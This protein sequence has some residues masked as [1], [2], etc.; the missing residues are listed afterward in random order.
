MTASAPA[1]EAGGE[2]GATDGHVPSQEWLR[3]SNERSR[4]EV[5]VARRSGRC[6][7]SLG[8]LGQGGR[9]REPSTVA[10][11][12]Q[13]PAFCRA[14][15][16]IESTSI[17]SSAPAAKPSTAERTDGP[18]TSATAYPTTVARAHARP[19]ASH[20]ST[21]GRRASPAARI[22]VAEPI[23]SGRLE[24]KIATSSATPTPPP[25]ARPI[26]RT[27]CSGMPSSRAPSAIGTPAVDRELRPP[28]RATSRLAR[29]Y[30]AAPTAS[31]IATSV[32]PDVASPSSASS[33]AT[34]E[35]SAP[36]PKPST[37]PTMPSLQV[38]A[39]PSIAP[40]TSEDA[41]RAP[42]PKA[43]SMGGTLGL[44]SPRWSCT[45]PRH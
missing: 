36:A 9:D 35:I 21:I 11:P 6:R 14:S 26:P 1:G 27:A 2:A 23:D 12:A 24:T 41:A 29:K 33:N 43:E 38:R 42:Q 5:T 17:T 4:V 28:I 25:E 18:T 7:P 32:G 8:E 39:T 45:A 34:L 30:A 20:S 3:T 40:S 10:S 13:S 22:A 31:P 16:T 44:T 15:G 19:T 37:A